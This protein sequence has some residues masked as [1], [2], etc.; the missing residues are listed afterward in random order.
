M[1]CHY[2]ASI[3]DL[4]RYGLGLGFFKRSNTLE[5]AQCR[6][7]DLVKKLKDNSLL[8]DA[9][10]ET[11]ESHYSISDSERFAMHDVICDNS[12]KDNGASSSHHFKIDQE[13]VELPPDFN[14]NTVIQQSHEE[15]IQQATKKRMKKA[16]LLLVIIQ[17][18]DPF[19]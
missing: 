11:S 14:L 2:D 5:K 18:E 12:A 15:A 16:A 1:G 9:P 4:F 17:S 8:L 13:S 7:E 6:V 10:N 3:R 19:V